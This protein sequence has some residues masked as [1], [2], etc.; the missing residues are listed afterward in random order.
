MNTPSPIGDRCLV[1]LSGGQDSATCLFWAKTQFRVVHAITFDYNQ[2]HRR[3]LV[4]ARAVARLA[5][6]QTHL[7]LPVGPILA[8]TSPLTDPTAKLDQYESF[9]AM[10][11][12]VGARVE[13]TFVPM[14]N[15][16]FL[17]LAANQAIAHPNGHILDLV[18]GVCQEDN[19][20]YPDCRLAFVAA[21]ERTINEALGL[22]G[23]DFA[24]HVPLIRRGKADTVRLAY[25]LPGC[26]EALA[27]T[28]TAYDGQYPPLGRDHATLLRAQGFLEADLPDPLVIRAWRDHWMP[29][30]ATPNYDGGRENIDV[31][32]QRVM[33]FLADNA[34]AREL[35]V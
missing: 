5:E 14:R 24:I 12:E 25:G 2:R 33:S 26:Y 27:F 31:A 23:Y 7:V 34:L 6:V 19:A 22:T 28:H 11:A 32:F 1:V 18:T 17:T 10:V 30:P 3:E 16:L 20:N 15:A 8:G 35:A 9:D 21:Q 29:L 13:R 4:A